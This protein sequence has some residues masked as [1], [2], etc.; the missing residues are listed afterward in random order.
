MLCLRVE[1]LG[2]VAATPSFDTQLDLVDVLFNK[3]IILCI[4]QTLDFILDGLRN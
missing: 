3:L 1:L 4:Y 2:L